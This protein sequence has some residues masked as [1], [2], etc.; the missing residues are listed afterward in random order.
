MNNK[1]GLT[2]IF[3]IGKTNKKV[4]LFN[5]KMK[6]LYQEEKNFNEIEDNDGFACEDIEMLIQWIKQKIVYFLKS[7]KYEIE[8]INFTT[9]GATL[10]YLDKEGNR[11]TPVYNYLKPLNSNVDIKLYEK[12]GGKDE[13]SRKTASPT[14]QMLNSGI[15]ILKLKESNPEVFSKV[16]SILH[17]PQYLSY[18][19]TKQIHSEATS[20]GCHTGLW[21]FDSMK[22]HNWLNDEKISFPESSDLTLPIE[23]VIN[24]TKV[25]VGI[26][27]HDSSASLVPYLKATDKNFV[28]VSTGTWCVNMNPFN[29]TKL[30]KHELLKDCLNYMTYEQKTVKSSRVFL[31]H[32]HDEN[33]KQMAKHYN[34][35]F[36]T[37]IATAL[38]ESLLKNLYVSRKEIK[39]FFKKGIPDDYIDTSVN[40]N[41][42]SDLRYAYHQFIIDLAIII[43][44]S[45]NLII[46]GK[47]NIEQLYITGGFARNNI[48]I[49]MLASIFE[50][51]S[52]FISEVDNATS[53]GVALVINKNYSN[54]DLSLVHIKSL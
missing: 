19:F 43:A 45:I 44:D 49:K 1:S 18:L 28:L 13:F 7:N 31:G 17:F 11:L 41:D 33:V 48:F 23:T 46:S 6:V 53:L 42:F 37:I 54:I 36:D 27:I 21:D 30:T 50:N 10:V 38:D 5:D 35:T 22:Y 24:N 25:N 16:H 32:I 15:Q 40:Y 8:K 12:Y 20:I 52:V 14:L 29:H 51:K 3:D 4:L 47:E 39:V 26:G 2:L 9:Y 34:K